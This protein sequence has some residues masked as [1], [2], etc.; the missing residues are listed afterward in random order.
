MNDRQDAVVSMYQ[1]VDRLF[2][3]EAEK[4]AKDKILKKHSDEFHIDVL[5]IARYVQAQEFNSKGFVSKKKKA[6]A[7]LSDD[8][9]KL[10]AG[11]CSF[12]IDT[13]NQPITEEFD[14]SESRVNKK[15]DADFVIYANRLIAQLGE[16]IKELAPYHITTEDLVN[17]TKQTQ[18]YSDLL[19][20]PDERKS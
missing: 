4:V 6:K 14:V 17:L 12:G 1:E 8:I 18:A 10:T 9:F 11:F 5:E 7:E 19:H 2:V 16:Y 3:S 13:D 15:N 20:L